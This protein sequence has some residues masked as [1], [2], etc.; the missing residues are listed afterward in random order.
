MTAGTQWE[1]EHLDVER[2]RHLLRTHELGRLAVRRDETV[3]IFPLN[4]LVFDDQL[5]FRSAPGSKLAEL[6]ASP[7]V[8]FEID[9]R[10]G[11]QL[12]SVVVHGVARRLSSDEEIQRSGIET[13]R[14]AHPS[15]KSNFVT[16][17]TDSLSGR[18]FRGTPRRWNAGSIVIVGAIVV[19]L[20]AVAGILSEFLGR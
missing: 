15:D 12:W 1:I 9:G 6:S 10:S 16:I 4:Y 7:Q 2:C 19:A 8:A 11:R 20:V 5:F 14:A 18:Q 17:S 13:L 3:D